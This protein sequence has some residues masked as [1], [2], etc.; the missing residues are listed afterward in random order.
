MTPRAILELAVIL[1]LIMAFV[2]IRGVMR[3]DTLTK[4]Q[5]TVQSF[6]AALIPLA[7]PVFIVVLLMSLHDRDELRDILPFPLYL[8]AQDH[9]KLNARRGSDSMHDADFGVGGGGGDGGD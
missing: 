3:D 2:A 1:H 8:L 7:G 9:E 6:I 4:S 5:Q